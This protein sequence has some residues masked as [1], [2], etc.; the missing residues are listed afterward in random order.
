MLLR[1]RVRAFH[2]NRRHRTAIYACVSV[3]ALILSAGLT[4]AQN[5]RDPLTS[6][7]VDQLR[8]AAQ[9]PEQRLKLWVKFARVRMGLLDDTR[10]APHMADPDRAKHTHELLEDIT[11]IVSE[12]ADNIDDYDQ[13][14][15]DDKEHIVRTGLRKGLPEVIAMASEFQ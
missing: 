15:S 10:A 12:I 6:K 1:Q 3:C 5:E 14:S 13:K 8:E 7:E 4:H 9:D 11:T 2:A